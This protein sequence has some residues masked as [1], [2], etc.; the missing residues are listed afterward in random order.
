MNILLSAC[1]LAT[2]TVCYSYNDPFM[3]LGHDIKDYSVQKQLNG[4]KKSAKQVVKKQQRV[5]YALYATRISHTIK[6]ADINH[7]WYREGSIVR[8]AKVLQ[9]MPDRVVLLLPSG[10]KKV[11]MINYNKGIKKR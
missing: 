9:I 4:N 5:H 1:L 10:K 11:L 6:L 7:H 8:K 2:S 3:P